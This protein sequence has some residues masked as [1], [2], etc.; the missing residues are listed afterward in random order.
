MKYLVPLLSLCAAGLITA[1]GPAPKKGCKDTGC[2]AGSVCNTNTNLCE[3]TPSTGGGTGTGGGSSGTGGGTGTGGGSATGGGAGGGG[4]GG[5]TVIVDPFNDGGTFVTGDICS[6]ALPVSFDG[7]TVAMATVDLSTFQDQYN[8]DCNSASSTGNDVLFQLT[9]AEAKGLTVTATSAVDGGQ[10]P[11]LGLYA[12]PCAATAEVQ[13][14]DDTGSTA[15]EVLSVP[16]L[17][18]GTYYV[19]LENYGTTATPAGYDVKFELVDPVAAAPNDSCA[20]ATD[21]PLANGTGTVTGTTIGAFT[22][23]AATPLTCSPGTAGGADVFYSFTLAAPQDVTLSIDVPTSSDLAPAIALLESCGG[24]ERGCRTGGSDLVRRSLPAGTH[25]VVVDG[26]DGVGGEFSLTVTTSAPTPVPG[27]DVCAAPATLAT[28]ATVT[29]DA[30]AGT[31]D[32]ALSC[33]ANSQGGDVVYQ[34]TTTQ[35]QTVRITATGMMTGTTN[36]DAVISLRGAP[37]ADSTAEVTCTD[38]AGGT[39]PEVLVA[40]NLPAGTY[41]VVVAAYGTTAGTFGLALDLLAPVTAPANDSCTAPAMVTLTGGTA[42]ATA[43]LYLAQQDLMTDCATGADGGEVVYQVEIPAMQT[44]TVVG[45]PDPAVDPV[46]IAVTP[47]CTVTTATEC[48]DAG[49]GGEPETLVIANTTAAPMM[50]FI[51]VQAYDAAGVGSVALTF[52]AAP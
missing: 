47:T 23:N 49:G 24:A 33:A 17:P 3:L 46:L 31:K 11:V 28:G 15:P 52:T 9:L 42:T 2:S 12:S 48:E 14:I 5:G 39:R 20:S 6:F 38:N 25:Y 7:G 41:F 8:S 1:C 19:L 13:C 40:P 51:A 45:T 32:Y 44:L 27:N 50:V 21:I 26:T 43:E 30:N 18:A 34:F 36:S 10:D 37:C 35:T 22:D 4:G 29:V 16:R